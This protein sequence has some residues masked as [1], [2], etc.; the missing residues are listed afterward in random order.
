MPKYTMSDGRAFTDYQASCTLNQ[1]LQDKYKV[2]GLHDFRYF[3]QKNGDKV[4]MD[5]LNDSQLGCSICP[6]CSK[7]LE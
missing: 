5:I 4:R 3:L 6:V 2:S 1:M 7:A